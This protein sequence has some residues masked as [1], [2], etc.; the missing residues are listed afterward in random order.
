MVHLGGRGMRA[1]PQTLE[2]A[3]NAWDRQTLKLNLMWVNDK[4]KSPITLT[5]QVAFVNNKFETFD[6]GAKLI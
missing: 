4:E 3:E 6:S 2:W 1:T 5:G